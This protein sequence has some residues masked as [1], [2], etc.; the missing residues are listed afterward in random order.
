MQK[1]IYA[2]DDEQLLMSQLWSP[3][4][5][6]D[7]E[8]FVL[9]A[10]PWGQKNT[11]LEKFEGPRKWQRTVLRDITRHLRENRDA[12]VMDALRLAVASGRGICKSA[13]VSWLILWM[14]TTRI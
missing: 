2:P 3:V 8:A 5:K 6:D 4:V 7:P 10:F 12:D 14:L 11:P 13:L 9:F 1:P